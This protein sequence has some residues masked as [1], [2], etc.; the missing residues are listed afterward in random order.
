MNSSVEWKTPNKNE[1]KLWDFTNK[2]THWGNGRWLSPYKHEY[3][4]SSPGILIKKPGM[5]MS[6]HNHSAG[7]I[8]TVGSLGSLASQYKLIGMHKD[9]EKPCHKEVEDFH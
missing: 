8:E 1:Y 6:A 9:N 4:S 5:L 7:Q 3:L 2:Q